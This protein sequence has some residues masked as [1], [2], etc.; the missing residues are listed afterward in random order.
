MNF[1]G[2]KGGERT[3]MDVVAVVAIEELNDTSFIKKHLPFNVPPHPKS[4]REKILVY[5]IQI[6]LRVHE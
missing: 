6:S 1:V 2:T 5:E 4:V 3:Y